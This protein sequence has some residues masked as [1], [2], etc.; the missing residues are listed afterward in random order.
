MSVRMKLT[1]T[2]ARARAINCRFFAYK[3]DPSVG[4]AQSLEE[5]AS[6]KVEPGISSF[7]EDQS[8]LPEYLAKGVHE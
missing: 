4:P 6:Y 7:A 8:G 2:N 1:H 3:Y 5:I